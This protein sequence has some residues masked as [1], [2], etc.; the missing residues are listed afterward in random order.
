M[1]AR[2]SSLELARVG[3]FERLAVAIDI[4]HWEMPGSGYVTLRSSVH[5]GQR[6]GCT[7]VPGM[8]FRRT[9]DYN[10][11]VPAVSR[12]RTRPNCNCTK[13]PSL[14]LVLTYL[15]RQTRKRR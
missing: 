5:F 8:T 9:G 14:G 15:E 1:S 3:R 2:V 7:W 13:C 11:L 6:L 10:R 12:K 4:D